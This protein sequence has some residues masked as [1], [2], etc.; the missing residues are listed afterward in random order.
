ME[1][2]C[3]A[4]LLLLPQIIYKDLKFKCFLDQNIKRKYDIMFKRQYLL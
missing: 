4:L 1:V 2:I 3:R